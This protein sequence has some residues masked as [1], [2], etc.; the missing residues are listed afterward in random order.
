M[1]NMDHSL[2]FPMIMCSQLDNLFTFLVDLK[3]FSISFF[4]VTLS[5]SLLVVFQQDNC[6]PR[7]SQ[8]CRKCLQ[9]NNS[10]VMNILQGVIR[11]LVASMGRRCQAVIDVRI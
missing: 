3:L 8:V 7:V 10:V 11:T 5:P 9:M 4:N 6:R 1:D 2:C